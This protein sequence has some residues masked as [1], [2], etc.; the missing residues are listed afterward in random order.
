MSTLFKDTASVT[1]YSKDYNLI[2]HVLLFYA[3][4]QR[5]EHSH[6]SFYG[7]F[8]QCAFKNNVCKCVTPG[9]A[10]KYTLTEKPNRKQLSRRKTKTRTPFIIYVYLTLLRDIWMLFFRTSFSR[11][12]IASSFSACL[13]KVSLFIRKYACL[14][15]SLL[16]KP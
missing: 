9:T 14:D 8:L 11:Q 15:F 7:G 2:S 13:S 12:L 5:C 6:Y 4:A 1:G 3:N 16:Y 10:P